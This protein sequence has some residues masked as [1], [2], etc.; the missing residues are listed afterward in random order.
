VTY[1]GSCDS[2]CAGGCSG[3]TAYDCVGCVLNSNAN[4]YGA[5]VCNK[6]WMGDDCSIS[7]LNGGKN[8][9]T[10]DARCNGCK[11]PTNLDC[12][13][14]AVNSSKNFQGACMCNS[15]WSGDDCSIFLMC[16]SKCDG[17]T[18]TS[19]FDCIHCVENATMNAFGACDCDP[20]WIGP[21]CK[22][23][24]NPGMFD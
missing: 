11:G 20:L 4:R 19:E 1:S 13:N 7:S 6:N 9:Y 15:G 18:G 10:C 12:L 5:C 2:K 21:S 22:T 8:A 23:E 16:D 24:I 14:C 3:P 17:C